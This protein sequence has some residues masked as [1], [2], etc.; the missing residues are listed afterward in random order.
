M[1][2]GTDIMKKQTS[3]ESKPRLGSHRPIHYL[4]AV[5]LSL[6]RFLNFRIRTAHVHS[7]R[8]CVRILES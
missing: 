4:L 6:L 2:Q 1:S 8:V 7:S 5:Y 3:C